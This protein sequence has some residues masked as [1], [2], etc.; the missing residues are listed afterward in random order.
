M[1]VGISTSDNLKWLREHGYDY[2]TVRRGG[3]TDDYKIT[4]TDVVTV[5]D[6]KK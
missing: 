6:I 1:D 5:E 2:I 3:S 4:G